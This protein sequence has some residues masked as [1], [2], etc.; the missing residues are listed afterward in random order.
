MAIP[1]DVLGT[2]P[3]ET[4]ETTAPTLNK[5]GVDLEKRRLSFQSTE[6][7]ATVADGNVD[8]ASRAKRFAES[9]TEDI[10]GEQVSPVV[11]PEGFSEKQIDKRL[12]RYAAVTGIDV[13]EE[14]AQAQSGWE[15]MAYFLPRVAAKATTEA[16]KIPGYMQGFTEWAANGFSPESYGNAFNNGWNI[17]IDKAN[18]YLQQ[19]ALPVYTPENVRSGNMFDNLAS[20]SWWATQGA[21][22]AGF[23]I[24]MMAPGAILRWSKAGLGA[25]RAFSAAEKLI[26][27]G[28][29]A[30]EGFAEAQKAAELAGLGALESGIG[31][32]KVAATLSKAAKVD[33]FLATAV[34]TVYESATEGLQTF[35]DYMQQNPGDVEGAGKAAKHT[36]GINN[37]I[38]VGPNALNQKWLFN[39]FN[40][41]TAGAATKTAIGAE[42]AGK[43]AERVSTG[44]LKG[45]DFA[46]AIA[47]KSIGAKAFALGK[48]G[49][50]G[51]LAEGFFE[52]GLQT[53]A[54]AAAMEGKNPLDPTTLIDSYIEKITA[55]TKGNTEMWSG[56]ILGA[57]MGGGMSTYGGIRDEKNLQSTATSLHSLLKNNFLNYNKTYRD[58]A[59]MKDGEP[60]F[61]PGTS[62]YD[63]DIPKMIAA[64]ALAINNAGLREQAVAAYKEGDKETYDKI[65]NIIQYDYMSPWLDIEGGVTLLKSHIKEMAKKEAEKDK[66]VTGTEAMS[67]AEIE[68]DLIQKVDR[69]QAIHDKIADTHQLSFNVKMPKDN[70]VAT[71]ED[72]EEFSKLTKAVKTSAKLQIDFASDR[73]G[74]I[75]DELTAL[76]VS[77]PSQ[78]INEKLVA[79]LEASFES[80]K[81][82]GNLDKSEQAQIKKKIKEIKDHVADYREGDQ[83]LAEAYDNKKLQEAFN[84]SMRLKKEAMKVTSDTEKAAAKAKAEFLDPELKKIWEDNV[85][86]EDFSAFEKRIKIKDEEG[87]GTTIMPG[88][89]RIVTTRGIIAIKYTDSKGKPKTIHAAVGE[90]NKRGSMTLRIVK[91]K[92]N[93]FV[94]DTSQIGI[95]FLNSKDEIAIKDFN[96]KDEVTI[97]NY[98]VDSIDQ[99]KDTVTLQFERQV[100]AAKNVYK[101]YIDSYTKSI[102]DV[103]DKLKVLQADAKAKMKEVRA[104]AKEHRAD[105]ILAEQIENNTYSGSKR[106]AK[107]ILKIAK[108]VS[109]LEH[110]VMI[111]D[112][113]VMEA[114]NLLAELK[115]NKASFKDKITMLKDTDT[116]PL[117]D[118]LALDIASEDAMVHS[119]HMIDIAK[120]AIIETNKLIKNLKTQVKR[121]RTQLVNVLKLDISDEALGTAGMTSSEKED[122]IDRLLVARYDQI[123]WEVESS[124]YRGST[125]PLVE[126]RFLMDH[127]TT[128][129]QKL[130]ETYELLNDNERIEK[131]HTRLLAEFDKTRAAAHSQFK[132]IYA[133]YKKLVPSHFNETDWYV[134]ALVKGT[135][136]PDMEEGFKRTFDMDAFEAEPRHVYK[137]WRSLMTLTSNQF[138]A[139]TQDE[140]LRWFVF[141][142]NFAWQGQENNNSPRFAFKS[143]TYD[144]I[145]A[146]DNEVL[147]KNVRFYVGNGKVMTIP[148]IQ[149][150]PDAEALAKIASDDI[151]SVVVGYKDGNVQLV[152]KG[153]HMSTEKFPGEF[154]VYTSFGLPG[155]KYET[156]DKKDK[157]TSQPWE[158]EWVSNFVKKYPESETTMDQIYEEAH[159]AWLAESSEAVIKYAAF[160][161]SLKT[162]QVIL[163]IEGI[164]PGV[165]S[166]DA[167]VITIEEAV[168]TKPGSWFFH[169]SS[170]S[171]DEDGDY[172]VEEFSVAGNVHRGRRG[173][174]YIMIGSNAEIVKPK[175]LGETGSVDNIFGLFK[176]IMSKGKDSIKVKTYLEQALHMLY[177]TAD[178]DINEWRL[179]F[180]DARD[181]KG[182]VIPGEIDFIVFGGE[183]ISVKEITEGGAKADLFKEFLSKKYWNFLKKNIND[184]GKDFTEWRY[185]KKKGAYDLVWDTKSGGYQGFLFSD[186]PTSI[187]KGSVY[188]KPRPANG[189]AQMANLARDPQYLNQS[190]RVAPRDESKVAASAKKKSRGVGRVFKIHYVAP[191]K[192]VIDKKIVYYQD[193]NS[194]DIQNDSFAKKELFDPK[195]PA[196]KIIVTGVAKV[197]KDKKVDLDKAAEYTLDGIPF[198]ITIEFSHDLPVEDIEISVEDDVLKAAREAAARTGTPDSKIVVDTST[199]PAGTSTHTP[200]VVWNN[201]DQAVKDIAIEEAIREL[202]SKGPEGT[203]THE[204]YLVRLHSPENLEKIVI[205]LAKK[206]L[207]EDINSGSAVHPDEEAIDREVKVFNDQYERETLKAIKWFEA[208]FPNIPLETVKGLIAGKAWGRLVMGTH[209]LISDLAESGTVY[210]EAFHVYNVLFNNP[211]VRKALYEE[212]RKRLG[213]PDMTDKDAEEFLAEEFRT[214]MM[215]GT[216]SIFNSQ[217][218]IKKTFFQ[219]IL[220]VINDI[221]KWLGVSMKENTADEIRAAFTNLKDGKFVDQINNSTESF[222]SIPGIGAIEQVK[223]VEDIN[224]QFFKMIV[225]DVTKGGEL[226][227][228]IGLGPATYDKLYAVYKKQQLADKLAGRTKFPYD[229]LF[230]NWGKL[231]KQHSL[232]L[233]Q[234][235]IDIK[236][237]IDEEQAQGRNSAEW[238]EPY[239]RSMKDSVPNALRFMIGSLKVGRVIDRA[240]KKTFQPLQDSEFQTM[241]N[242]DYERVMD[243]LNN[244]MATITTPEGLYQKMR[245]LIPNHPE[246]AVLYKHIGGNISAGSMSKTQYRLAM[247]FFSSFSNSRPRARL[248]TIK[249]DGVMTYK[250]LIDETEKNVIRGEWQD[251][252][253]Q[254]A[255]SGSTKYISYKNGEFIINKEPLIKD[256]STA[257]SQGTSIDILNGLGI[258]I[259]KEFKNQK[260][261]TDFIKRLRMVLETKTGISLALSNLYDR[262]SM[263]MQGEVDSLAVFTSSFFENDQDLMYF[264]QNGDM[265]WSIT[266]NSH[267]TD[268]VNRVN[269]YADSRKVNPKAV[270]GESLEKVMP[271]D[272]KTGRGSI[273]NRHSRYWALAEQGN[274]MEFYN[275]KGLTTQFGDGNETSELKFGDYKVTS[276]DLLLRNIVMFRRAADRAPEYAFKIGETNYNITEGIFVN[277]LKDY[278]RDEL[279]TTF[280]LLLEK[281]LAPNSRQFGNGLANYGENTEDLRVFNFLFDKSFSGGYTIQRPMEYLEEMLES[282]SFEPTVENIYQLTESYIKK[283]DKKLS[284]KEK[285]SPLESIMRNFVDA[286]NAANKESLMES[287]L[288]IKNSGKWYVPGFNP[289]TIIGDKFFNFSKQVDNRGRLTNDALD[290]IVMVASY[291]YLV[292]IIEQ[293]KLFTGDLASHKS[294]LDGIKRTTASASTRVKLANDAKTIA[295]LNKFSPKANGKSHNMVVNEVILA[296]MLETAP[297]HL[298]DKWSQYNNME[299]ADGQMYG[300]LDFVRG[301]MQREG[302][303]EDPH[304]RTYQYEMQKLA[305]RLLG[306]DKD[307][308]WK[309]PVLRE[310]WN[311]TDEIFKTG[312]FS[313]HTNGEVPTEPMFRAYNSQVGVVIDPFNA[314]EMGQIPPMKQQGSGYIASEGLN[315]SVMNISKM[316][317]AP[318]FP[319]LLKNRELSFFLSMLEHDVDV[320]GDPSVKKADYYPNNESIREDYVIDK[321]TNITPISYDDYGPQLAIQ[322]EEKRKVTDSTQKIATIYNNMFLEGKLRPEF[323]DM[324][325]NIY[326]RDSLLNEITRLNREKIINDLA[327]TYNEDTKMYQIEEKN[328]EKFKK[329][330]LELFEQRLMPDNIIDGLQLALDSQSKILDLFSDNNKVEQVLTAFVRNNVIKRKVAGEMLVQ[331]SGYLYDR[332]LKIYEEGKDGKPTT[333][334]EVMV[335][336]PSAWLPWAKSIGG[337]DVVN[338]LLK[339]GKLDKKLTEFIANRIPTADLNTIEAFTIVE[340]LPPYVGAK[341]IL[342]SAIVAKTSSDFDVDKLTCYL[343]SIRI[344]KNGPVYLEYTGEPGLTPKGEIE[345][346]NVTMSRMENRIN[347]LH[348]EA[349]LHH[350]RYEHLMTPHS[351][352]KIKKLA[353]GTSS[354]KGIYKP[355]TVLDKLEQKHEGKYFLATQWW[356]N[357]RKTKS[358]WNGIQGLSIIAATN[359]VNSMLQRNPIAIVSP[360]V[361]LRD[362][363]KASQFNGLIFFDG[364]QLSKNVDGYVSGHLFDK[365]GSYTSENFG[366]LIVSAVDVSKDD[367]LGKINVNP[368]TLS[369]IAF[370]SVNGTKSS[371]GL[372]QIFSLINHEAILEYSNRIDIS[373]SQFAKSN[374]YTGEYDPFN[375]GIGTEWFSK[376]IGWEDNI[377]DD[378]IKS[379]SVAG[380]THNPKKFEDTVYSSVKN[381]FS[382]TN[383]DIKE[384][385]LLEIEEKVKKYRYSYLTSNALNN[386]VKGTAIQALDNF[387]MY[388]LFASKGSQLNAALRPYAGASFKKTLHGVQMKVDKLDNIMDGAFYDPSD[389]YTHIETSFLREANKTY[390]ETLKMYSWS[391]INRKYPKLKDLFDKYVTSKYSGLREKD[392]EKVMQT[393]KNQFLSFIYSFKYA[394][395]EDA[396][397]DYKD[398]FTGD[399]SMANRLIALKGRVSNMALDKLR[400]VINESSVEI[401]RKRDDDYI[402]NMNRTGSVLEQ[403]MLVAS[404]EELYA[405]TDPVV[406]VFAD[407]FTKFSMIQNGIGNSPISYMRILPNSE[408]IP[409]LDRVVS[410]FSPVIES[411]LG[412]GDFEKVFNSFIS[413]FYRNNALNTDIVHRHEKIY[414]YQPKDY[415]EGIKK[416]LGEIQVHKWAKSSTQ[417]YIS[418][419]YY[420][421]DQQQRYEN[422]KQGLR[423]PVDIL[424]Y[425]NTGTFK[426]DFQIF[427]L[428]D[429]LGD[430]MRFKEYYPT[431]MGMTVESILPTN[432]YDGIVAA[433]KAAVVKATKASK[434][435]PSS[436]KDLDLPKIFFAELEDDTENLPPNAELDGSMKDFFRAMQFSL[437]PV[438]VIMDHTGTKVPAVAF[439]KI[440]NQTVEV[441]NHKRNIKTLPEE[442]AHVYVTMLGE[443]HPLYQAMYR[444]ITNYPIYEKVI[445]GYN[446]FYEGDEKRLREEAMGK[447]IA[448]RIVSGHADLTLSQR[449]QDQV[450]TWFSRLWQWI[451]EQFNR[452]TKDS[453]EKAA[454]DILTTNVAK[455]KQ[456]EHTI[457][458]AIESSNKLFNKKDVLD[459]MLEE[460]HESIREFIRPDFENME[461][462][463]FNEKAQSI[464][465]NKLG[466]YWTYAS[467]NSFYQLEDELM[468]R[469]RVEGPDA[470]NREIVGFPGYYTTYGYFYKGVPG[471]ERKIT[472]QEYLKALRKAIRAAIKPEELG[473]FK[474]DLSIDTALVYDSDIKTI[475][476]EWEDIPS[477]AVGLFKYDYR[478]SIDSAEAGADIYADTF[479]LENVIV[480]KVKDGPYS[481][482]IAIMKPVVSG[483]ISA[484]II[485]R[486]DVAMDNFKELAKAPVPFSAEDMIKNHDIYFPDNSWLT[487][488]EKIA[489]MKSIENGTILISCKF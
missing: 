1:E 205:P 389:V 44:F 432:K 375:E 211:A 476:Q 233:L 171:K 244:Q 341:I 104:I 4:T 191:D 459:I 470:E 344:T 193:D 460:A 52:E 482:R 217:E 182:V 143:Y 101:E 368:D 239:T 410:G 168:G 379:Y 259:G 245:E 386:D 438:G 160:R 395:A 38:L 21:D 26:K 19:N 366:Q 159:K 392:F 188:M 221:L 115:E 20:T 381:Y 185:D 282:E 151:K 3:I 65:K 471:A 249:N 356:F 67:V 129:K 241:K 12:G 409:S 414:K 373:R 46:E 189:D 2:T 179:F 204:E 54:S 406:Q 66:E 22:G 203:T 214:F 228:E 302:K 463:E 61:V 254:L 252:G 475:Q 72:L 403:N 93:K 332:G 215:T 225:E 51:V 310:F 327:L 480:Q 155:L 97:G 186:T 342:P 473:R 183:T 194:V 328:K 196:S 16:L 266:R 279:A 306:K 452:V 265:E 236:D 212:T 178:K 285:Y 270:P 172:T 300:S 36:F 305:I 213:A 486:D 68:K 223:L 232:H 99:V 479:G 316:S 441:I 76:G 17:S 144:Q 348:A 90:A 73:I 75:R 355:R 487:D 8:L 31:A 40:R 380:D 442:A 420:T 258:N 477:P 408:F 87:T 120:L 468:F 360:V 169:I 382:T 29:K 39:G 62:R 230:N 81:L 326:E 397:K 394:N 393:F 80:A 146:S 446:D 74:A 273:Y 400:G 427:Q 320:I 45:G 336:M 467:L 359:V 208:K 333:R 49:A 85:K 63:L 456:P 147:K 70:D 453:Y 173:F 176:H 139:D 337:I 489:T 84:E 357:N 77:S 278:L 325:D 391:Q 98:K 284:D 388:R 364:Q 121:Y 267:I 235:K 372:K 271:Y 425:R 421:T 114:E 83:A 202:V 125:D 415:N 461:D 247:Q 347:E 449:Q 295:M 33:D 42:Q 248:V 227:F 108:I 451:K 207:A 220:Q 399:H 256:L 434:A 440:W 297:I 153:G 102:K 309:E 138:L 9:S 137:D 134:K 352:S 111:A 110:G 135:E 190:L 37:L 383:P 142:N 192:T 32:E 424:F 154:P 485:Q 331:E 156:A 149:A 288:I 367:Y 34:N 59:V 319:S 369:T 296:P 268:V 457:S 323:E 384:K 127:L 116:L 229:H 218:N 371:V 56:I 253:Q 378:I 303:W 133:A 281:S 318:I 335:P 35:N 14:M 290:S 312:V 376:N 48:L 234:Y 118:L 243:L 47:K 411:M 289:E 94:D 238:V 407:D 112:H 334:A 240:G 405:S 197:L 314:E 128:T 200:D 6:A 109:D 263:Q 276:F 11:R 308:K 385:L 157:F 161:E 60:Q 417:D 374:Q 152:T 79:E 226:L 27:P 349:I 13:A 261:V 92:G 488:T 123:E 340:F 132:K 322:S 170:P 163:S 96:E 301:L 260:P 255:K 286:T 277:T 329:M 294:F 150:S 436:N 413:Q 462:D 206:R 165:K 167:S 100:E 358:F 162:N 257:F 387:L 119:Q 307:G 280:A 304:E 419:R 246:L 250:D 91:K 148:E 177:A 145:L 15:Q 158:M 140:V 28:Y 180:H 412:S 426:G 216:S 174:A 351:G 58:F 198:P 103:G 416:T 447:L 199:P 354:T 107:R 187:S 398:M 396:A 25:V 82:T 131:E 242:V 283:F 313:Y 264:N 122:I 448:E 350:A 231:V 166:K 50:K 126:E 136:M 293:T 431:T 10:V 444:N 464:G 106:E 362:R 423:N 181:K 443:S 481:H 130:A 311:I 401:G 361:N 41:A 455:L 291:N 275:I 64:G 474:S 274:R 262:D 201:A 237:D 71:K 317:I 269:E 339:E 472:K 402:T 338:T 57:L 113:E 422:N 465:L 272:I 124:M 88:Q 69:F 439:T 433:P 251:R 404:L 483:D 454:F 299:I 78:K 210:H 428:V 469:E 429:K 330:L 377:I 105:L 298:A 89:S 450:N 117:Q 86:F 195:N 365:E 315:T 430:G 353:V 18:E 209:V 184:T 484:V 321:D 164:N 53:A 292:G 437:K 458:D 55:D 370:L 346:L 23:L 95:A 175:T 363:S 445:E 43:V 24:G 222:D 435:T 343:N 466:K 141:V 30:V 287:K 324:A 219:K 7:N 5:P 224:Y 418:V 390:D 478:K 345:D